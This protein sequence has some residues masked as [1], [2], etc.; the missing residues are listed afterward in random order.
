MSRSE[1]FRNRVKIERE[2]LSLINLKFQK[3]KLH[4]LGID[5]INQWRDGF[6]SV[7]LEKSIIDSIAEQLKK[8]SVKLKIIATSSRISF[9]V[10][11]LDFIINE[12][13]E[14]IIIL[15]KNVNP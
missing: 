2:T 4:G 15:M 1:R 5:S 13:Q 6:S 3:N 14:E 7:S 12:E 11:S 9:D 8:I 10:D